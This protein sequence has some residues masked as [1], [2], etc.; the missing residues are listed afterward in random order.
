VTGVRKGA[1]GVR[2][3]NKGD[4]PKNGTVHFAEFCKIPLRAALKMKIKLEFCLK[5][6]GNSSGVNCQMFT[7]IKLKKLLVL[8]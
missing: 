2:T 8:F 1:T 5:N 7:I 3:V 4:A 6:E